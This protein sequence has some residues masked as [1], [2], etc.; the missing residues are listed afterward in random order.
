VDPVS[1]GRTIISYAGIVIGPDF[2]ELFGIAVEAD[3]SLVVV[4]AVLDAV[5]RV[6][7][8]VGFGTIVSDASIVSG[9][10]FEEPFGIIAVEAD[11]SLLVIDAEEELDVFFMTLDPGL[12]MISLP[13]MPPEPYT[14]RTLAE[15]IG[16]TIVIRFDTAKQKF[17]GF[18]LD[19]VGEGFPVEGGQ[20]Y[21][22]NVADSKT[23]TFVGKAWT[24]SP[25]VAAPGVD[26]RTTAWAFVLSG[27][28]QNAELNGN[29]TV[30]AKNLR[31]GA[32]ATDLV[33]GDRGCFAA[34][35]ADL[36]RNSVVEAGDSL[37][38]T[39][40]DAQGNLAAGPFR[41]NVNIT[42]IRKAYLSLPLIVGDVRPTETLLAQNFPN[43]FNPETWIPFQLAESTEITIQ[44]YA[45][46]GRLVRKLHL[47]LKPAGFYT[48]RAM[49]AYWDGHND[50]GERVASGVYFYTLQTKDFAATR[51]M[52]IVK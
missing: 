19:S 48:T 5:V 4:D 49:A 11:D 10:D 46:S 28:V 42:N 14:A 15:Q 17:I 25:E 22:V 13:L 33:S 51:K 41:R 45:Q 34:V 6:D 1:G 18:T 47:G 26:V 24:N 35:W 7:A 44:I 40:L 16:A 39:L 8:V 36:N 20:G 38:I 12:N 29:Y 2:E 21:I 52:L 37:E 50:A 43:P 32:A 27:E 3:G 23:T 31:T 30:V 9:P